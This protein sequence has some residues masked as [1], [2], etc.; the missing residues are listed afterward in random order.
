MKAKINTLTLDEL[1]TLD[2][3]II[4]IFMTAWRKRRIEAYGKALCDLQ[5]FMAGMQPSQ[6]ARD[7]DSFT[8]PPLPWQIDT[9]RQVLKFD[10]FEEKCVL[11]PEQRR[12]LEA[13]IGALSRLAQIRPDFDLASF[14]GGPLYIPSRPR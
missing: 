7:A 12:A 8:P 10:Y 14:P 13:A 4:D 2:P 11:A 6:T 1:A 3:Q 5:A 9:I